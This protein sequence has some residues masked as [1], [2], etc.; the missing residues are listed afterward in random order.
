MVDHK[1]HKISYKLPHIV[2]LYVHIYITNECSRIHSRHQ[3]Y[4]Q[5]YIS[6]HIKIKI[7]ISVKNGDVTA[8]LAN[9]YT[10]EIY[11]KIFD[12]DAIKVKWPPSFKINA[13]IPTL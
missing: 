1:H 9:S 10:S 13:H 6:K 8:S 12:S 7:T 2:I 11:L 4:L 5:H 3:E